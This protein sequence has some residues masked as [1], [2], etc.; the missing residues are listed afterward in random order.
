MH[1]GPKEWPRGVCTDLG[2]RAG[3]SYKYG[4]ALWYSTEPGIETELG[5]P[6]NSGLRNPESQRFYIQ[7]QPLQLLRRSALKVEDRTYFT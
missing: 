2:V 5:G 3:G 1:S 7:T 6:G 4:K